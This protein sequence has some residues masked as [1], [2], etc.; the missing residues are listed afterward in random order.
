MD[1]LVYDKRI[2]V[3]LCVTFVIVLCGSFE[4][5][6]KG[7]IY[8]RTS[9]A[10]VDVSGKTL[11]DASAQLHSSFLAER[12][13]T[14]TLLG[15]RAPIYATVE[16]LSYHNDNFVSSQHTY[17]VGRDG[18]VVQNIV[19]QIKTLFVG[20][21]VP[22][23]QGVY[24]SVTHSYLNNLSSTINTPARPG[25][26]GHGLLLTDWTARDRHG[27]GEAALCARDTW[28]ATGRHTIRFRL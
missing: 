17:R 15:G 8:P 19:Q 14:I 26:A 6:A 20:T 7:H 3:A 2:L 1:Q 13:R 24:M 5:L 18:S 25:Q 12:F 9:V 28:S 4:L 23:V 16:D 22:L 10:G 21:D 27:P 11:E